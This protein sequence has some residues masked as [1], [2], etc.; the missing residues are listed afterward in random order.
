MRFILFG[1]PGVGKGTQAKIISAKMNIPHISTG[2]ILR[3]AVHNKTPLGIKADEVMSRGE[4]VSDEIMI[5]IIKDTLESQKCKNG[6]IM[7]GFPRTI[8]QA[9]ELE[10]LLKSL[11]IPDVYLIYLHAD[12]EEIVRRLTNRRACKKC[13]N[14]FVYS[15]IEGM[16]K[17]PV[18]GAEKSFYQRD[19]DKEEVIRKRIR[20]FNTTTKP[21][22]TFYENKDRVISLDGTGEIDNITD[23]ILEALKKKQKSIKT[24]FV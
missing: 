20:V 17:C 12:E 14:I 6:F 7:D 13:Q 18:C 16:A 8:P 2:D 1:S 9:E 11:N 21:V 15:D 19:D 3:E 10:K 22:Y 24:A 4:L 5:G 23:H